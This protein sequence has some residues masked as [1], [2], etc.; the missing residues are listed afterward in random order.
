MHTSLL[1]EAAQLLSN[2]FKST[3]VITSCTVLSEPE[4]RN[5]IL[6]L[7]LADSI[8]G[9]PSS[10]ILKKTAI[11]SK[12]ETEHEQLNRFAHDWAGI[13]FLTAIG[14]HHGPYFYAGSFE[15]LFILI[16]DL[17]EDHPSLVGPLTRKPSTENVAEAEAALITYTKS[18]AQMH[19]DTFGKT[20]QFET[21]LKRIYPQA[22]RFHYH[23]PDDTNKLPEL[24]KRYI[25]YDNEH[26]IQELKMI[27][28]AIEVND[29]KVLLHGDICPDNVFF[30]GKE[31]RLFDFEYGDTGHALIDGVYLRMSMPS[32]WCSK[33][34][35]LDVVLKMEAIYREELKQK[36]PAVR[37]DAQYNQA[38]VYACAYWLIRSLIWWLDE[39]FETEKN[40]PS[41]PVDDDSLWDPSNN[42]FRPRMISRL[43]AFIEIA[44]K[45]QCLPLL[46]GASNQLLILL[47]NQWPE[48]KAL[49]V[50]PVFEKL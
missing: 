13:E 47:R 33:Q 19:A 18:V 30:Q 24:F 14:S 38:I 32:C 26:L 21:I 9:I 17:G 6:R 46:R 2:H 48:A 4:R 25:N 7:F 3:V 23:K 22:T 8:D 43:E 42:G 20:A 44:Q 28:S 41:G 35:P 11:E 12:G 10:V 37:D 40:C 50:Y 5:L 39:F 15:H 34:T 45:H 31:I 29:F 1:I 16:E 27:F 36:I 49:D